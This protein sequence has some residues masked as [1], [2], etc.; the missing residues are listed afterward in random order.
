M[1]SVCV[2]AIK[3]ATRPHVPRIT[4]Y[5]GSRFDLIIGHSSALCI[6]AV[7]AKKV[8]VKSHYSN[9]QTI[10]SPLEKVWKKTMMTP[11][12]NSSMINTV[13]ERA[14]RLVKKHLVI[15]PTCCSCA[16]AVF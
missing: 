15:F 8:P 16:S 10:H 7:V 5:Q 3:K 6:V 14:T 13:N 12:T 9:N 2:G 11:T 4:D 1:A